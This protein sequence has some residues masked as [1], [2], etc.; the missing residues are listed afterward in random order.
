M[1][2]FIAR[3]ALLMI[4]TLWVIATLTFFM[5]RLAPGGPFLAERDI[6][7]RAR[8]ALA[9]RYG[10]DR[11]LIE[12][13]GR[14]LVHAAQ[15]DFG[16]SYKRPALQVREIIAQAFPV[17][18]S[19]GALALGWA[20]LV[21]GLLGALAAYRR[22]TWL[23]Y[24]SMS[25][26]LLGVSIPNFV[27]GP[28]LVLAFSLNLYWFPP[29]QWSTWPHRVLPVVTLSA[30]YAATIARLM[31]AGMV[32]V[33]GQDYIR[34]ARAKGLPESQ[35]VGRHAL[36][37]GVLPLVSYLGPATAGIV[38]GSVAVESIFAVPGLGRQLYAAAINRDYTVV[39]GTVLFYAALL[40]V[41]NL[42]VDIL[43]AR[44]DPR[45]ELR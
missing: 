23:D 25:T 33:L 41:L 42:L 26:A 12:Q 16:P 30:V 29:A 1:T 11:P 37:P 19:L 7:T 5:L 32:E 8:A 22:N 21:G 17:S 40:L 2:R 38:T 24:L 35:V 34:T 4:P 15:L 36:R 20:L 43:Y 6:P 10:L 13:Y 9:A 39:L 14:F 44:L 18:L 45:V 27:L 28:L 31:R 3:R